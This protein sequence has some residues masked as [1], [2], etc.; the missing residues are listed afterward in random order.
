MPTPIRILV[1]QEVRLRA[2]LN[3]TPCARAIAAALPI[4]ASPNTWGEEFYFGIGLTHEE[5]TGASEEVEVGEI[6]YWPPGRALAIFF[7]RTPASVGEK[8]VAASPVNRVGRI[9]D[10]ATILRGHLGA[11][12]IRITRESD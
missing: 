1:D 11:R 7:G 10:D 12:V 2:E 5:E 4:E 3:D 9:L 6:G 8:P